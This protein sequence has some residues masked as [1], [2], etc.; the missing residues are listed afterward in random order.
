MKFSAHRVITAI[1]AIVRETSGEQ[2]QPLDPGVI[3]IP[4][5]EPDHAGM[6]EATCNGTQVRVFERDL[7]ERSEEVR[8]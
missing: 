7:E 1:T 4:T 6:I 8:A 3:V 2:L 5:S